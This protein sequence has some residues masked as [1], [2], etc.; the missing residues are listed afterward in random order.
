MGIIGRPRFSSL[1]SFETVPSP[2]LVKEGGSFDGSFPTDQSS[3]FVISSHKPHM[4]ELLMSLSNKVILSLIVG[5][6]AAL[7]AW[8]L[9]DFTPLYNLTGGTVKYGTIWQVTRAQLP[10][11]SLFGM[12]VGLGLGFVN[13]LSSGSGARFRRCIGWGLLYGMVGGILGIYFGQLI[14]G[15]MHVEPSST[16]GNPSV[17]P[18]VFLWNILARALGWA[19]IGLFIG[20]SQG[21]PVGSSKV[22]RHGAVGGF[23]GGLIG[24]SLFEIIPYILPIGQSSGMMARGISMTVTGAFIGFFIGLVETIM[25]QAWIRVLKGRNEGREYII[26]KVRTTIGRDELSDVG[27]FGDQNIA[28]TH[29]AI[30]AV[31]GGRHIIRDASSKTGTFVNGQK[32]ADHTL[33]DGEIIE[34]GSSKLEFHEKA[35]MSRVPK[36]SD[37]FPKQPIQIPV[38]DGVCPFCGGRKDPAT[39]AC[40]CSVSDQSPANV[41][42]AFPSSPYV[43]RPPSIADGIPRLISIGGP[44]IGQAFQFNKS[45]TTTVGRDG[46]QDV[47]IQVDTTVSRHHAHIVNEGGVFVVYDD[48]SSNGTSVNNTRITRQQIVPGDIVAFGS[49]TFRFEQ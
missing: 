25:K 39:G 5:T 26:S 7:F 31:G 11:A 6:C 43:P 14:Y 20:L 16:S 8:I 47:N 37:M 41:T 30:D 28:P 3:V 18:L 42:S 35:T 9:I 29:A 45:G 46:N 17:G 27:L 24:G 23:L 32:I 12:F 40:A 15:P 1:N 10:I 38:A 4:R 21:L 48:G 22:A 13:G 19:F 2:L 34:I 44:Y 49:S 33:R 36:K